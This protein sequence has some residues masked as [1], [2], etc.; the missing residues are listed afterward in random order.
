MRMN[1]G[2]RPHAVRPGDELQLPSGPLDANTTQRLDFQRRQ[3]PDICPAEKVLTK[4]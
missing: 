4:R 3:A 2:Y 1:S